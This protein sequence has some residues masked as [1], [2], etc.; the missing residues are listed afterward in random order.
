MAA[1]NFIIPKAFDVYITL[2]ALDQPKHL[3]KMAVNTGIKVSHRDGSSTKNKESPPW[4]LVHDGKGNNQF[5]DFAKGLVLHAWMRYRSSLAASQLK[6]ESNLV[7]IQYRD[8]HCFQ[9]V[10]C[11]Y[12]FLNLVIPLLKLLQYVSA[13]FI[14]LYFSVVQSNDYYLKNP[15]A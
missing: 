1:C 6:R 14:L 15:K 5:E 2:L 8:C 13:L 10:L 11:I 12:L 3:E 7:L 9:I 4:W